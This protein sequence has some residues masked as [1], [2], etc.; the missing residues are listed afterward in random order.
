MPVP[1]SVASLFCRAAMDSSFQSPYNKVW[2]YNDGAHKLTW[3]LIFDLIVSC[4]RERLGRD[5][6]DADPFFYLYNKVT[7]IQ[8]GLNH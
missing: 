3:Y 2:L 8:F 1:T 7:N 4:A 6:E 5:I